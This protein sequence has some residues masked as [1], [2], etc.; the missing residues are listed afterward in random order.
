MSATSMDFRR[1][2]LRSRTQI[3]VEKTR[4]DRSLRQC[5][6]SFKIYFPRPKRYRALDGARPRNSRPRLNGPRSLL[7]SE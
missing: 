7:D 5:R 4:T 1:L 2:P 3:V 6:S